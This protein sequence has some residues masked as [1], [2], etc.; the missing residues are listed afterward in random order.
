MAY[1]RKYNPKERSGSRSG[2]S[3]RESRKAEAIR[4]RGLRQQLSGVGHYL[5]EDDQIILRDKD[6]PCVLDFTAST[7]AGA[8]DSFQTIFDDLNIGMRRKLRA[9]SLED[10]SG[11]AF[12]SSSADSYFREISMCLDIY[13]TTAYMTA[14][15]Y[16]QTYTYLHTTLSEDTKAI[17]KMQEVLAQLPRPAAFDQ[18]IAKLCAPSQP[19]GNGPV[20]MSAPVSGHLWSDFETNW[21]VIKSTFG[22]EL[23]KADQMYG[24][25]SLI[26]IGP[27]VNTDMGFYNAFVNNTPYSDDITCVAQGE[28]WPNVL[29]EDANVY[30][31][32]GPID[33]LAKCGFMNFY[34]HGT[35]TTAAKWEGFRSSAYTNGARAVDDGNEFEALATAGTVS[36]LSQLEM[37]RVCDSYRAV[38]NTQGDADDWKKSTIGYAV[39]DIPGLVSMRIKAR[40]FFASIFD[41]PMG[42]VSTPISPS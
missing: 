18:L 22:E 38:I 13:Y 40:E 39:S 17:M 2:F 4:G 16:P 11:F 34:N 3:V 7:H 8:G 14:M 32:G 28:M 25:P 26:E 33:E 41:I 21:G 24:I 19:N 12:L 27:N 30:Y 29:A 9:S 6:L 23:I 20:Y 42:R 5:D 15:P 36:D 35:A 10:T 31:F 37:E 1:R